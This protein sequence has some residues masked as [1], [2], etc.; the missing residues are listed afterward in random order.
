MRSSGSLYSAAAALALL[1]APSPADAEPV[2]SFRDDAVVPHVLAFGGNPVGA[3]S[4]IDLATGAVI[5][6]EALVFGPGLE[7]VDAVH[8][9]GDGE[10]LFSTTTAAFIDGVSYSGGDVIRFDPGDGSHSLAFSVADFDL[11]T[12]NVDAVHRLS[13]GPHAGRLLLSTASVAS[14]G[15]IVM[16]PGDLVAYDTGS[17]SAVLVFDQDLITGTAAQKDVDAVHVLPSGDLLLSVALSGG[18]L[19]GLT[20]EK[21]DLILYDPSTGVAM[22]ALDG[23]GLFDGTTADL[24]ALSLDSVQ[25]PALSVFGVLM[26]GLALFGSGAASLTRT[27]DRFQVA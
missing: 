22:V 17:K 18:S 3:G 27:G 7:D 21:Q 15:G 19:G 24:N 11:S 23:D 2:V 26:L 6:D 8:L 9:L 14:L 25:L 13:T 12:T 20:L 4:L 10:L 16:R 5:L 1:V